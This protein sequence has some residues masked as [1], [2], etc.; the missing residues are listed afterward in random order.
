MAF[1]FFFMSVKNVYKRKNVRFFESATLLN[2]TVLSAGTLYKWEST[3]PKVIILEVSIGIT[4]A[5]FCIIVVWNLMKPCLNYA[6]RKCKSNRD[7]NEDTDDKDI[8]HERIEDPELEPLISCV[9]R[10]HTMAAY[11]TVAN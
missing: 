10:P 1:L 9:S 5:Q 8:T 4:F 6:A 2:L 7:F 11:A 3:G